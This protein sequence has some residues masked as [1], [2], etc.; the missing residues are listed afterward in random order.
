[1][2]SC[3]RAPG[4]GRR[5][6]WIAT[7]LALGSALAGC[8]N[9]KTT[10][11]APG[12]YEADLSGEVTG[13]EIEGNVT[14]AAGVSS[15]DEIRLCDV[16]DVLWEIPHSGAYLGKI[17]AVVGRLPLAVCREESMTVSEGYVLTYQPVGDDTLTLHA[18]RAEGWTVSGTVVVSDYTD[19]HPREPEVHQRLLS[20]TAAGTFALEAQGPESAFLRFENGTFQLDVFV[21]KD[22]YDPFD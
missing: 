17:A 12:R 14:R 1:M 22:P 6:A 9:T 7:W 3:S 18:Q 13:T 11:E 16:R 15:D 5:R 21:R 4:S 8:S 10:W 2:K 19:H 20:E